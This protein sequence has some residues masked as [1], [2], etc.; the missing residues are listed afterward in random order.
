MT[1]TKQLFTAAAGARL[2]AEKVF[3]KYRHT[4]ESLSWLKD[5]QY[6]FKQRILDFDDVVT[7][8]NRSLAHPQTIR[9]EYQ[10]E[11]RTLSNLIQE[12]RIPTLVEAE[13]ESS[14]RTSYPSPVL[15][16][17]VQ[18]KQEFGWANE[19][20]DASL[21]AKSAM[22]I[23]LE[24]FG[25]YVGLRQTNNLTEAS[26]IQHAFV[27]AFEAILLID[28]PSSPLLAEVKD[29]MKSDAHKFSEPIQQA[30][31]AS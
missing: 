4:T 7:K 18:G 10:V 30:L 3:R 13:I 11:I 21:P 14:Q 27:E 16:A 15:K 26:A 6:E 17:F 9:S 31:K 29:W 23:F 20:Y 22:G 5:H 19:E 25:R 2:F 12:K 24:G 8:I 1:E 28:Y